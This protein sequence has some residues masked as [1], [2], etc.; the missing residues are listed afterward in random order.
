MDDATVNWSKERYDEILS[1]LK[2]FLT[3]SGF[4]LDTDCIYMPAS[5]LQSENID[6]VVKPSVCKWYKD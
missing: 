1:F 6:K 2:P 4:N 5:G 3:E